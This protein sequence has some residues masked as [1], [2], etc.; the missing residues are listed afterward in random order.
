M[1]ELYTIKNPGMQLNNKLDIVVVGKLLWYK[2]NKTLVLINV[3][4]I[5]VDPI[6]VIPCP[7]MFYSLQ[8]M[9]LKC[10]T[11]QTQNNDI[12]TR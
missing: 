2:R 10:N 6:P 12:G 1:N 11:D 5:T 4:V 9:K 7:V 8:N 3:R